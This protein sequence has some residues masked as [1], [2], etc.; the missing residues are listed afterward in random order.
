MRGNSEIHVNLVF[1]HLLEKNFNVRSL[2]EMKDRSKF[3]LDLKKFLNDL[4]HYE[5]QNF[6]DKILK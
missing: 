5:I 6:A 4:I 1:V 3:C 2:N